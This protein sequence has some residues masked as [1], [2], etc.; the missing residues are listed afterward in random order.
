MA[1]EYL[2]S[3][4][5]DLTE[6]LLLPFFSCQIDPFKRLIGFNTLNKPLDGLELQMISLV[7]RPLESSCGT[8]DFRKHGLDNDY[9]M[10][11]NLKLYMTLLGWNSSNVFE[12][13]LDGNLDASWFD[14]ILR[15][16]IIGSQEGTSVCNC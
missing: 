7:R 14:M 13:F 16:E 5:E 10:D 9:T 3:K 12:D 15:S 11:D 4:T 8:I 2:A 1:L 6:H